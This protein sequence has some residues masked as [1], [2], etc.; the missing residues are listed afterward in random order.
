MEQVKKTR[1]EEIFSRAA[2]LFKLRGYEATTMR[3]IAREVGIE[4]ASLYN[5]I[6]SKDELL[7]EICF[8]VANRYVSEM[9][10]IVATDAAPTDKLSALI[11]LHVR[12]ATDDTAAVH[13]ANYEWKHLPEADLLAFK[14][15]RKNYENG[16]LDLINDGILRGQLNPALDPK[17]ALFTILSAV[18]WI[19][20]WYREDRHVA[21]NMLEKQI[22]MILMNGLKS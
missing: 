18:R 21:P 15:L 5:H 9:N 12:L 17:V 6:R 19:G 7:R 1:K 4:A 10:Q 13:I 22:E 3:D 8:Q 14:N 20:F 11:R 16:F 2:E